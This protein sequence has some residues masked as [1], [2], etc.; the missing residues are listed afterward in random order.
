[1]SSR[2]L[3]R[4]AQACWTR[5]P[6]RSNMLMLRVMTWISLRLGR[7]SGRVVLHGIAAYFLCFAPRARRAS[8]DYLGRVLGREPTWGERYRHIFTLA[9][10]IPDRLYLLND[11]FDLFDIEVEGEALIASQVAKGKGALLFGAHLGSFEVTRAL[12]RRQ[13]GLR[14]ALAMYEENAHRVNAILAA[15]N[16][17]ARPEVIGLNRLDAMLRI[18]DA[19]ADDALVGVLADRSLLDETCRK[20]PLL[21]SPAALPV[22]PFRMAAMLKARV[23]FMS[24]LYRGA[25][26]YTI[27]FLPI[28]DFSAVG[29]AERDAAIAAAMQRYAEALE[30][31]CRDAPY[32]WFNFYPFWAG[33]ESDGESGTEPR[34]EAN[35]DE[36]G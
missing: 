18:R 9:A 3:E 34:N 12:G 14:I 32:N 25:N 7:S 29:R 26:R 35:E 13:P 11:R 6:E 23:I 5:Y 33:A 1:M 15:I 16:P 30:S 24:G 31:C 10:T 20:I 19:L 21:G 36:H 27:R 17:A 28:A 2:D 8:R 4:R 22:S